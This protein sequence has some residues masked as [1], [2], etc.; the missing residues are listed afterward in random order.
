VSFSVAVYQVH[1]HAGKDSVQKRLGS[2]WSREEHDS[3]NKAWVQFG[4]AAQARFL[5]ASGML[6]RM[7]KPHSHPLRPSNAQKVVI[8]A[9]GQI[10]FSSFSDLARCT[11]TL[12]YAAQPSYSP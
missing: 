7:T 9:R 8:T 4:S 3:I 1:D 11:K 6:Y 5:S 12:L 10:A 2:Q